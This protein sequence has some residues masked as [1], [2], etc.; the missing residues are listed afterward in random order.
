MVEVIAEWPSGGIFITT[1]VYICEQIINAITLDKMA[2]HKMS[3][4]R[5]GSYLYGLLD[6][7][8]YRAAM[9]QQYEHLI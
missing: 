8:L 3:G 4:A 7:A 6:M 2:A 1:F 9:V 5:H